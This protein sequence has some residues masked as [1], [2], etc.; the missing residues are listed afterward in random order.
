MKDTLEDTGV[1]IIAPYYSQSTDASD[2]N[3][4]HSVD[5]DARGALGC[6]RGM[7]T[8]AGTSA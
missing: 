7:G 4:A 8:T 3:S 2:G 5:R 6:L 1:Y